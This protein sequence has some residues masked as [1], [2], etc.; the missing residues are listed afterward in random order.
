MGKVSQNLFLKNKISA[1]QYL[2]TWLSVVIQAIG[3]IQIPLNYFSNLN[4]EEEKS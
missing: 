1:F 2:L 3:L 4:L